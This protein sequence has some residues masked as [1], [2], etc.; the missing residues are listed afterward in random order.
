MSN[1]HMPD[2]NGLELLQEIY[3]YSPQTAVIII[4]GYEQFQ[5]ARTA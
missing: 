2:M 5:Y 3:S 1:I 4:S